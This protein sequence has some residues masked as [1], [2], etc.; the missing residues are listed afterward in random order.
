MYVSPNRLIN[1]IQND[2]G[3]VITEKTSV[4][5]NDNRSN[6]IIIALSHVHL[7]KIC[8]Y[9]LSELLTFVSLPSIGLIEEMRSIVQ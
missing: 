5:L 2:C 6:F 4:S 8:S 7:E 3:V 9:K 1:I